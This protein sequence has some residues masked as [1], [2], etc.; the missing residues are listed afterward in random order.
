MNKMNGTYFEK[1]SFTLHTENE[2][3]NT[4]KQKYDLKLFTYILSLNFP[5]KYHRLSRL[6]YYFFLYICAF[7]NI[8]KICAKKS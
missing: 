3:N 8:D 7:K 6:W 2:N 4:P 5:E 1:K